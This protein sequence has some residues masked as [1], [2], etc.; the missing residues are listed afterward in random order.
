MSN[1]ECFVFISTLEQVAWGGCEEL[2]YKT[3]LI[4]LEHQR[5]VYVVVFKHKEIPKHLNQLIEKGATLFY[6]ERVTANSNLRKRAQNKFFPDAEQKSFFRRLSEKINKHRSKVTILI[7]QAGGFDFSYGYL[8]QVNQWLLSEKNTYH[9]LVQ[10]VPD[11]GFTLSIEGAF[12]QKQIFENAKTVG[13]VSD[14]NKLSAE[15]ILATAI[16]NA[17]I[18]NNPLNLK[19]PHVCLE[20]PDILGVIQFA[21]VAALKCSHK[22]QD[23]LFQVLSG[24]AWKQRNWKLNLYGKGQDEDYLRTLSKFYKIEG[25]VFFHGHTDNISRIWEINHIHILA[26]LG[27]GTPL[28]LI[29]SMLCGRPVITTDVGGN[30]EYAEH[31]VSGFIADY[32]TMPALSK[33]MELAWQNKERWE[34]MGK[35][36]NKMILKNYDLNSCSTLYQILIK[37]TEH[38]FS[39]ND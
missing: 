7:S 4:A 28:A 8:D 21:E 10:N 20:Y 16:S 38:P 14:R 17:Y 35:I 24:E 12:K 26:S 9:V 33:V 23:I 27:E 32:P 13:F 19:K 34:E 18:I 3:A 6:L 22:G 29:E 11:L 25:K 37:S 39:K 31:L 2:W 5:I 1:K 30:A 36:A 15:R